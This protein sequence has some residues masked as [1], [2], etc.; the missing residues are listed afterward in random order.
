[1]LH[2]GNTSIVETMIILPYYQVDVCPLLCLWLNNSTKH[3]RVESSTY[4]NHGSDE[5]RT[6]VSFPSWNQR[7]PCSGIINTIG[8]IST[9]KD[10]NKPEIFRLF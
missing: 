7:Y 8:K 1:M 2:C 5:T 3:N 6:Q 4:M 10:L 9:F